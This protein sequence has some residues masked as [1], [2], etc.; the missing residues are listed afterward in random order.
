MRRISSTESMEHRHCICDVCCD[1]CIKRSPSPERKA[2]LVVMPKDIFSYEKDPY[3]ELFPPKIQMIMHQIETQRK[4]QEAAMA[5]N[6]LMDDMNVDNRGDKR[7]A[8]R[9]RLR[10][11]LQAKRK[12]SE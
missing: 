12:C 8:I 1:A 6:E 5:M 4:Y 7:S 9:E 2:S 10:K 3:R 11:K